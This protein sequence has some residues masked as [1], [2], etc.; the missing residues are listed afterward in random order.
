MKSF[1]QALSSEGKDFFCTRNPVGTRLKKNW[2]QLQ[3]RQQR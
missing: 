3:I 1:Q 2:Q